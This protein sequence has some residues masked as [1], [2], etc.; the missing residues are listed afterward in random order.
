MCTSLPHRERSER[1]LIPCP[2]GERSERLTPNPQPPPPNPRCE[3]SEQL[4]PGPHRERGE[5]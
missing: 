5:R 4:P 2:R 1:K 3:R